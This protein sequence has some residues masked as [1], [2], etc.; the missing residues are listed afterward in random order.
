MLETNGRRA[1]QRGVT[2]ILMAG[3]HLSLCRNHS[4]GE[5]RL[6]SYDL[7]AR[8]NGVVERSGI[9]VPATA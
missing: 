9:C 2:F 6:R 4:K 8:H 3:G 1:L 7:I 5:D